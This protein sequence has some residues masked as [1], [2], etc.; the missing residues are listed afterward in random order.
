VPHRLL[1][2]LALTA[3]ALCAAVT[4]TAAT[5]KTPTVTRGSALHIKLTTDSLGDCVAVVNYRDSGLQIGT[6][7]QATDGRLAWTFPVSRARP[8][9][10]ATW[11]VRC[12]LSIQRAG[13][14]IVVNPPSAG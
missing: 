4:A 2:S 12:G 1:T 5:A 13:K 11:Y 8:L 14:F 10:L 3:A 7:K 9:G 6:V